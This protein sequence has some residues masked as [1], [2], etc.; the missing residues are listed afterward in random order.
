MTKTSVCHTFRRRSTWRAESRSSRG[1][2]IDATSMLTPKGGRA[3]T[4]RIR[5]HTW[6]GSPGAC[7]WAAKSEPYAAATGSVAA[8]VCWKAAL[9]AAIAGAHCQMD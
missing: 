4:R 9:R 2:S 7:L 1:T 6:R 3:R 8:T 5:G